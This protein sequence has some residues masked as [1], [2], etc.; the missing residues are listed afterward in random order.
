M[1]NS[2]NIKLVSAKPPPY[3]IQGFRCG[4]ISYL[5]YKDQSLSHLPI[6]TL[7]APMPAEVFNC[8]TLRQ[9]DL[10]SVDLSFGITASWETWKRLFGRWR[11]VRRRKRSNTIWYRCFSASVFGASGGGGVVAVPTSQVSGNVCIPIKSLP[12]GEDYIIHMG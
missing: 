10:S 1:Y 3:S 12:R 4:Q 6:T 7:T 11:S 9:R 5:L 8:E 2:A